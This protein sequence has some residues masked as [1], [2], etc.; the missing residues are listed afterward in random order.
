MK[1]IVDG[2]TYNTDTAVEICSEFYSNRGDFRYCWETLYV[3]KRGAY[4]LYGE[5]GPLSKYSVSTGQNSWSG[6]EAITPMTADEAMAWTEKHGTADEYVEFFGEPDEA[7]PEDGECNVAGSRIRIT[8]EEAGLS[9]K[10]LCDATGIPLRTL[11][12]YE[13]DQRKPPKWVEDLL[14]EK[15]ERMGENQF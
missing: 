14:V 6:G 7:G 15:I 10:Q 11:E 13:G 3:T 2:K 4:F 9:R 1:K 5:G 12:N 8:R